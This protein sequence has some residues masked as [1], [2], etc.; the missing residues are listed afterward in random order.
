M[1][2]PNKMKSPPAEPLGEKYAASTSA[3][4]EKVVEAVAAA[5]NREL[6]ACV[7]YLHVSEL[8]DEDIA[9]IARAAIEAYREAMID[10]AAGDKDGR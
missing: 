6:A 4:T 2:M 10:E 7:K 1:P 5:I 3:P 9:E 8:D